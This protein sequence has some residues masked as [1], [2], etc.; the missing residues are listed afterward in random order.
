MSSAQSMTCASRQRRLAG[1][2]VA[3]PGE[4]VGVV[5]V[6]PELAGAGAAGPRVLATGVQRGAGQVEA[7]GG[8]AGARTFASSRVSTRSVCA[9]P[10]KPP[11]GC[12][13]RVQGV[14]AVV[15]ERRVAEVVGQP[16]DVD[17]VRVA[18]QRGRPS[19]GRSARP[20]ASGSAGC[21]G[22][23][24]SRRC[25]PGS[26]VASRRNAGRVQHPGP[27]AFERGTPVPAVLRGARRTQRRCRGRDPGGSRDHGRRDRGRLSSRG[28]QDAELVA[29][30]VGQHPQLTSSCPASTR[31]APMSSSRSTS[32]SWSSGRK[33]GWSRFFDVLPSG[34]GTKSRP[35]SS[36]R[37]RP[38]LHLVRIL[39]DDLV[40]ERLGPPRASR[41]GSRALDGQAL[42]GAAHAD[43][44]TPARRGRLA[45]GARA[46]GRATSATVE[47]C[48]PIADGY[49]IAVRRGRR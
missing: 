3:Q 14:L 2:A 1:R 23:R 18:A 33:S 11:H 25:A 8:A 38:D 47:S 12:G 6:H 15:P 35:G 34:T 13:E 32:A 40:A 37:L 31:R 5:G 9:L 48:R 7:G 49:G 16:G 20:R 39:V 45:A 26:C 27:V 19:P 10:S 42:P 4:D 44:V 29:L 28:P 46:G 43:E 22:S 36:V 21:A 41:A 17:H 24:R 30:R